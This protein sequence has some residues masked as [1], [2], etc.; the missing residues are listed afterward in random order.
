MQ[1]KERYQKLKEIVKIYL[2][3]DVS[4]DSITMESNF[5]QD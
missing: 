2:P 1:E 4:A 5:T 3:D